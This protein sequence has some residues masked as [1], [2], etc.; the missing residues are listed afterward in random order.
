MC[1]AYIMIIETND[2]IHF[3]SLLLGKGEI[4]VSYWKGK[5]G[6]PFKDTIID[7]LQSIK[8]GSTYYEGC[9]CLNH[10]IDTMYFIYK[11]V[12]MIEPVISE[13]DGESEEEFNDR[14]DKSLEIFEKDMKANYGKHYCL[15]EITIFGKDGSSH[16]VNGAGCAVAMNPESEFT[17]NVTPEVLENIRNSW[18]WFS[19]QVVDGNY[20]GLPI[21]TIMNK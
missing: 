1:Y 10:K 9:D 17:T 19:K 11:S 14:F 7:F 18:D 6:K 21:C 15:E 5:V 12:S 13:I 16:S 3:D 8:T 4:G 20:M 2:S